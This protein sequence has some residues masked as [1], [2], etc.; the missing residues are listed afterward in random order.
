M[1]M[2]QGLYRSITAGATLL[3]F[4]AVGS[5][6]YSAHTGRYNSHIP[7]NQQETHQESDSGVIAVE[8][9]DGKK[10]RKFPW[11]LAVGGVMVAGVVVALLV[12]QDQ[13]GSADQ[14]ERQPSQAALEVYNSIDWI[15]IPAGEFQMGDNF[16]EGYSNER[17][18]HTVY[19]DR[20]YVSK[21]EVTFGLYDK[22][23]DATG[24]TKPDDEGRGRGNRPAI[25]IN[26]SQAKAFCDWLSRETGE[27]IHL[28]TEAQWEKAARG[29]DQR[30]YPWGNSPPDCNRANYSGCEGKTKP[31]G[32]CPS[33]KS[34]Y[35]VHDMAGNVWEWCADWYS[36]TY[37][38]HSPRNNPQ[39]P[40]S[41]S[42]RVHRGGSWFNSAS[43]LRCAL[44]V[45]NN[46]S[47]SSDY[48]GFRLT[49]D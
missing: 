1:E 10:T 38:S 25:N 40:S 2:R 48:I 9:H 26:W 3:V 36:S 6:S 30:R 22:Y 35:G 20:Y 44:R 19:L 33:G 17:P 29:T 49:R 34:P 15:E 42:Y 47:Y 28:P 14:E 41:G 8:S 45:I 46:P 7:E 12:K 27:D 13:S 23:C 37:Y 11:L 5:L 16:N 21:Y 4:L 18:V 32:S 24:K 39:G 43:Y 31:V